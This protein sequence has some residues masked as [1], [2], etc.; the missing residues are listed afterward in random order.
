MMDVGIDIDNMI[1]TSP[2]CPYCRSTII[3][4]II[5]CQCCG[6]RFRIK[7]VYVSEKADE[8]NIDE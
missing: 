5:I 2:Q 4:Q 6:K 8:F 7:M 1:N 3:E